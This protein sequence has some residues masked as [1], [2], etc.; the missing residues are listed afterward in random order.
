LDYGIAEIGA[1]DSAR[2]QI[3]ITGIIREERDSKAKW[4]GC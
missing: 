1:L 4:R 3:R 2:N